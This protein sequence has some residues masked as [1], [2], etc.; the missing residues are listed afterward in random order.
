MSRKLTT[1]MPNRTGMT[2]PIR[3]QVIPVRF[4]DQC[5]S[6]VRVSR[7]SRYEPSGETEKPFTH[8]PVA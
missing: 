7:E 3:L 8:A 4:T 1:L 5:W 2:L 6:T